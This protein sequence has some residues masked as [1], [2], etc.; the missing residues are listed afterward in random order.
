MMIRGFWHRESKMALAVVVRKWVESTHKYNLL[1]AFF[2]LVTLVA[3][4]SIFRLGA[5]PIVWVPLLVLSFVVIVVL[6]PNMDLRGSTAGP[7]RLW[8]AAIG[9][10]VLL[11]VIASLVLGWRREFPYSGDQSFHLKQVLY[12]AYWWASAPGSTPVGILGH[13]L[14]MASF[15]QLLARPWQLAWSRALLLV[16]ITALTW[17][18]YRRNRLGAF[19]FAAVALIA[20]AL[21]ERAI[22]LRYPGGGYVLAMPFIVPAFVLGNLEL[23]FRIPNVVAGAIWLF[24]LRPW[25]VGR[26]PDARVLPVAALLFWHKDV[27]YYLDSAYLEPWP[28]VLSLLAIEV[29]IARGR[30]GAPVACLLIGLTATIKEPL[31]FVLPFIWLAGAP[32]KLARQDAMRL[33]GVAIAAGIP[34]VL[35]YFARKNVDI[36]DIVTD[37]MLIFDFSREQLFNFMRGFWLQMTIAYPGVTALPAIGALAAACVL[38]LRDRE[39]R[40]QLGCAF[41]AGLVLIALMMIDQFGLYWAGYFRYFLYPL[42]FLAAGA[43][44]LGYYLQPRIALLVGIGLLMLQVPSAY[45]AVARSAGPASDRNFVEFFEAPL[46]FPIKSLIAEAEHKGI[47][48][49]GA[50]IVANQPDDAIRAVPGVNV[51]FGPLGELRCE[52]NEQNPRVM[53]LFIRYTNMATPFINRV[54]GKDELFAPPYDRDRIWRAQRAA[55]PMCIAKLQQT[56]RHVLLRDEGGETVAALGVR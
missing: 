39:R 24:A 41:A 18:S 21:C 4:H 53:A 43:V 7:L 45:L 42:P 27:I 49:R 28:F 22:Y 33:T 6:A 3:N 13:T 12:M 9:G 50:P 44:A 32:W 34:F 55:R 29:L 30:S 11:P 15:Q 17:W 48:L 1:P 20:W 14:D 40:L 25:L 54:P 5:M 56:C 36:A 16:A 19:I 47:L 23:T 10:L 31:V 46:V 35:Y 2:C 37:R 52:C 26:W 51:T 38:V 8:H